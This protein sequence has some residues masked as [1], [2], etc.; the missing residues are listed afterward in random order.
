MEEGKINNS[1]DIFERAWASALIKT[2]STNFKET[3]ENGDASNITT[4]YDFV[5]DPEI[6][7]IAGID[8]DTRKSDKFRKFYVMRDVYDDNGRGNVN[9]ICD[10]KGHDVLMLYIEEEGLVIELLFQRMELK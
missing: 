7:R 10:N 9:L 5:N 1:L 3:G 2:N 8:S 6:A 4:L